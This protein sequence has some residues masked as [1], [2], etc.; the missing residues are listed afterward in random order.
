MPMILLFVDKVNTFALKM[1]G[2]IYSLLFVYLD[3]NIYVFVYSL[4]VV[5]LYNIYNK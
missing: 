3:H 5:S 4:C 1:A 2:Q